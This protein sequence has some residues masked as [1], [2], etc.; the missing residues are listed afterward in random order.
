MHLIAKTWQSVIKQMKR[1]CEE[2]CLRAC[3]RAFVCALRHFFPLLFP[4]SSPRPFYSSLPTPPSC[5]SPLHLSCPSS[6]PS[7]PFPPFSLPPHLRSSI[8]PFSQ[9]ACAQSSTST[10]RGT[11]MLSQSGTPST[12]GRRQMHSNHTMM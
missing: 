9:K 12:T 8:A 2:A 10:P 4:S 6:L 5:A 1:A 11:G 3:L 7:F